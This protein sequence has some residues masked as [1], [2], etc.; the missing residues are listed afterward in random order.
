[1]IDFEQELYNRFGQVKDFTLGMRIAKYFYELGRS[2][3]PNN[4]KR[5][6]LFDECVA[7][8][9]PKVMKEVSDNIDKMLKQEG[10]DD[11]AIRNAGLNFDREMECDS[12]WHDVETFKA[13]AEYARKFTGKDIAIIE[14]LLGEYGVEIADAGFPIPWNSP[15]FYEEVARR[16]NESKR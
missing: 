14:Q 11:A 4:H 15:E 8:C 5:N 12:Y 6:E 1:M 2:E 13:G 9:D 3:K 7:K 16:F 10:L